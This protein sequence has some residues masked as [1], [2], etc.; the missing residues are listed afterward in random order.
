[1]LAS[2]YRNIVLKYGAETGI[3][4]Q[5]NGALRAFAARD[6]GDERARA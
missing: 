3:S 5:V 1:M 2:V 6:R 4:A